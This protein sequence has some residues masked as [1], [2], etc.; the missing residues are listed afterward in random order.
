MPAT[1]FSAAALISQALDIGYRAVVLM[2]S[3]DEVVDHSDDQETTE[4]GTGPVH[5]AWRHWCSEWPAEVSKQ[6]IT[7]NMEVGTYQK[8]KNHSGS[9]KQSA[10]MLIGSPNRP[11]DQRARGRGGP[12]KRRQM[13]QLIVILKYGQPDVPD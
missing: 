3:F 11:N 7:F 9:R 13:K 2:S 12:L 6:Y 1:E 5:V 4:H 10:A 8:E